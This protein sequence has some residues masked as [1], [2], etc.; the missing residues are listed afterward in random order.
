M[1][2]QVL[3]P[4]VKPARIGNFK[5]WRS[6]IS[7]DY[8]PE[9]SE[10]DRKNAEEKKLRVKRQKVDIEAINISNLDGS[11]MVRIPSTFQMFTM[12]TVAYQWYMSDDEEQKKRGDDF[13]T[14]A[15]TNMQFASSIENGYFHQALLMVATAYA[16][17]DVLRD[18]KRRKAFF[19]EGGKLIDR[20]LKWRDEFDAMTADQ[21]EEKIL[22]DDETADKVSEQLADTESEAAEEEKK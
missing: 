20:F 3:I 14:T 2:K 16:R 11:W 17:P 6:K 9:L 15:L 12:L 10:E 21:D 22:H 4:F 8:L 5:I 18:R 7:M 19:D 1:E 13:L